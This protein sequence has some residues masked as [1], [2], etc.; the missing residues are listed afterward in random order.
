MRPSISPITTPSD[1]DLENENN[2]N[3]NIDIDNDNDN[4][5]TETPESKREQ[6]SG[7][8][9]NIRKRNRCE[10]E[11]ISDETKVEE[12]DNDNGGNN[13]S[14]RAVV[15]F[16][17][18]IGHQS[19]KLRLDEVLLPLALPTAL[20]NQILKGIRSLPASILFYGPPGCGKT[21]LA[22]ALAGEAD[23]AFLS[24]GPSDILSKYVGESEAAVR[25]VFGEALRMARDNGDGNKCTVL[26]FDE[27][28]ALGQSRG[29]GSGGFG[30][31]NNSGNQ[32]GAT[33]GS[34]TSGG[35]GG[36]N[37]SRRVLAELLIQLNKVNASYGAFD[38]REIANNGQDDANG[39]AYPS[40]SMVAATNRPEDCDPALIR[41]FA[42]QVPVGLPTAKDRKKILKE[43]MKDIEHTIDKRQFSQLALVTDGWSGSDLQSLAREAAMAP[44]RECIRRAALLKRR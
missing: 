44:V 10:E 37:P 6:A 22:R 17:D 18:I 2:I 29:Q 13:S 39:N 16:K 14:N 9:T 36:D 15:R 8:T 5:N 27:I 1:C 19:V 21:Q 32:R 33:M 35:T 38:S 30:S 24:I 28:D 40:T 41:R 42:I 4:D 7:F 31:N 25:S 20:S 23:A 43:N 11:S 3:I 12:P 34:G 26:F